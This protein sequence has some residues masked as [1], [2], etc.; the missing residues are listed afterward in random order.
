MVYHR[1][2][3]LALSFSLYIFHL[4]AKL[5]IILDLNFHF[6]AEDTQLYLS[7]RPSRSIYKSRGLFINN[8]NLD[9]IWFPA[10]KLWSNWDAGHFCYGLCRKH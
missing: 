7:D 8:E 2:L 3:F 9:V 10:P 4:F 5:Y 6:Y 1:A